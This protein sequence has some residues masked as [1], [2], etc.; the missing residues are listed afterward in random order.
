MLLSKAVDKTTE[1]VVVS[2]SGKPE[3]AA[4]SQSV[5]HSHSQDADRLVVWNLKWEQ[6]NS[7]PKSSEGETVSDTEFVRFVESLY[8][9]T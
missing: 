2:S 3:F 6:M 1:A 7:A 9:C 5:P 8:D 4:S